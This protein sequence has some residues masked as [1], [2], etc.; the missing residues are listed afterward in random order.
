MFAQYY[1]RASV[2]S[3]YLRINIEKRFHADP[4][5]FFDLFLRAFEHVHR[6]VSLTPVLQLQR[7]FAHSGNLIR[8][9]QT[10]TIYQ[11]Q[12]CHASL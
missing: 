3:S 12:I 11:S 4:Q 2:G 9:Q 6:Y 7:R 5:L 1:L 10:H 8:G